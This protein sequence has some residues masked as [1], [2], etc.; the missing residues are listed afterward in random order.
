VNVPDDIK[1][2]LQAVHDALDL[3]TGD[4]LEDHRSRALLLDCRTSDA[5]IM[6]AAVIRGDC[7]ANVTD[8]LL[9]WTA[10]R[11]VTYTVYVPDEQRAACREGQLA[12]Q[13]RQLQDPPEPPPAVDAPPLDAEVPDE[14]AGITAAVA[15]SAGA[16]L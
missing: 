16:V 9:G 5:K 3:P 15:E 14:P 13:R 4:S 12:E 2:L 11:P 6:L 10:D 1:A 8:Q 7:V